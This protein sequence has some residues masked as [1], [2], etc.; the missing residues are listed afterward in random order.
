VWG[1]TEPKK[2]IFIHGRP[3]TVT[4]NLYDALLQLRKPQL[5]TFLWVDAICINQEDI[6]ERSQQIMNMS[7]IYSK[8]IC[9]FCWLGRIDDIHGPAESASAAGAARR[10]NNLETIFQ[11]K[12]T[13]GNP[14][15]LSRSILGELNHSL[16]RLCTLPFWYRIW[17]TQEVVLS[18]K[19]LFL[20]GS[21]EINMITFQKL[22]KFK[23]RFLPADWYS[24]FEVTNSAL[25]YANF[26]QALEMRSHPLTLQ[27]ALLATKHRSATDPR[28]YIYGMLAL[29]H[30][31]NIAIVPDYTKSIKAVYL[32]AFK[33]I[34]QQESNLDA[35]SACCRGWNQTCGMEGATN[36]SKWPTWLPDWSHASLKM[37]PSDDLSEPTFGIGDRFKS[38]LLDCQDYDPVEFSASGSL[39]QSA[40]VLPGNEQ[41]SVRGID[42]DSVEIEINAS[43]PNLW[44]DEVK[45]L[46]DK[47]YLRNVYDDLHALRYACRRTKRYGHRSGILEGRDRTPSFADDRYVIEETLLPTNTSTQRLFEPFDEKEK[48]ESDLKELT[49][50]P[51]YTWR[52]FLDEIKSSY[53]ITRRGYVGRSPMPVKVGDKVC[54]FWGGKVPFLLRQQPCSGLLTLV[55]ET[56][57]FILKCINNVTTLQVILVANK[58]IFR[59]SRYYERGCYGFREE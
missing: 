43:G 58:S 50:G 39:E 33:V 16:F 56:C 37:S 51:D 8:V 18:R 6:Q 10:L 3:K 25:M 44:A 54:I 55:G 36:E 14:L 38:V 23:D 17:I 35:L 45:A 11:S 27:G 5:P 42:F 7:E 29:T 34:L 30:Q 20:W 49:G 46:W 12:D 19:A 1:D 2:T 15:I 31:G 41:L 4:P 22:L 52:F 57:K 26:T 32:E 40:H 48:C 47:G 13:D 9:V 28:D 53:F 24:V 59:Y 21:I